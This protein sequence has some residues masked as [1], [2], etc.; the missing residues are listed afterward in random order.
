MLNAIAPGAVSSAANPILD[1]WTQKTITDPSGFTYLGL[2]APFALAFAIWDVR[3]PD[4]PTKIF[5]V[6][7]KQAVDLEAAKIGGIDG[8][9]A[10]A[11]TCSVASGVKGRHQIRWYVTNEEGGNEQVFVRDFDVLPAAAS[12]PGAGTGYALVSDL[13]DE[14][15][16]A[17]DANDA[18]ILRLL[19]TQARYIEKITGREFAPSYKAAVFDGSG[20]RTCMF[21]EPLIALAG[22]SLGQPPTTDVVRSSFRVYNRH[23]AAAMVDPDD[24]TDPKIEFAHFSDLIL[25]R[26]G[27]ALVGSPLFGVPW[28]DHYFPQAVQNVTVRGAWGYT[29]FDGSPTGKTPDLIVHAQ[30]LLVVRELPTMAGCGDREDARKR[31]RITSERT[32]DQSYTKQAE[33]ETPFTG[34]REID[35]I[36]LL[37]RRPLQLGSA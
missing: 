5:P 32:R 25:G 3:N 30:K 35:D 17:A 34:D 2:A 12:I 36:L 14:G 24:R 13:R 8:H 23:L 22:V 19:A 18:R 1:F 11:W 6:G 9:Y 33:I 27:A 31:H 21:G 26:R 20:G 15:V 28:R 7:T 10:A 16:G 29:D 4:A 37:Y